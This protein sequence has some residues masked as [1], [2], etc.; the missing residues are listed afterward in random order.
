MR[1]RQLTCKHPDRDNVKM[2]CGYPLPCPHHTATINLG[3][4]PPTITIPIEADEALLHRDTL[5]DIAEE[6][7]DK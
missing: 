5:A 6:L 3:E 4:N 2:M 1:K 7:R